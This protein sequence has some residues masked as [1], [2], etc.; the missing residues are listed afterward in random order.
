MVLQGERNNLQNGP[1][2]CWEAEE[3][4]ERQ[5]N[6][7]IFQDSKPQEKAISLDKQALTQSKNTAIVCFPLISFF[8]S[9]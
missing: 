6:I 7:P 5:L 4:H 1:K 3:N 2:L 9:S 8:F